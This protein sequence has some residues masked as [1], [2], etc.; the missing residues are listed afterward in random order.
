MRMGALDP[1][2]E[3]TDLERL[4][5]VALLHTLGEL[6]RNDLGDHDVAVY[7]DLPRNSRGNFVDGLV[8]GGRFWR[9]GEVPWESDL[10][11]NRFTRERGPS[12][13]WVKPTWRTPCRARALS[14]WVTRVWLM[15]AL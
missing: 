7:N 4:N 5:F 3:V 12:C 15:P 6:A 1:G 9:E 11:F 2:R 8:R 10:S 14:I 13:D